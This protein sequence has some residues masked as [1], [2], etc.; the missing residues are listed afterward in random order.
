MVYPITDK[1]VV[2]VAS[3]ALFDLRESDAVFRGEGGVT[4]YRTY[5]RERQNEPL[6]AGIAFPFIRRLLSLNGP[7]E[8]DKPVEVVLL[9]RNDSDTGLRVFKSDT[10]KPPS[11]ERP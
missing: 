9:S 10:K 11:K 1:V 8:D 2:A 7:A 3:S 5:Q 6:S 4:A